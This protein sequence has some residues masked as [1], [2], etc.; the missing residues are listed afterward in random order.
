[1]DIEQEI[2]KL[3]ELYPS[4]PISWFMQI[5]RRVGL[6]NAGRLRGE[7]A[8]A[9]RQT[10][11]WLERHQ[12]KEARQAAAA[13]QQ[14]KRLEVHRALRLDMPLT[15]PHVYVQLILVYGFARVGSQRIF[16]GGHTL[17]ADSV[18]KNIERKLEQLGTPSIERAVLKG[19]LDFLTGQGVVL[20]DPGKQGALSLNLN[21]NAAGV[22]ETGR[23]IIVE[24]KRFFHVRH[25]SSR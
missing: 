3:R 4:V 17:K 19:T 22:T 11:H 14:L 10:L 20:E 13:M 5:L 2:R 25:R 16:A 15:V 21:E 9:E 8:E 12:K 24:V 1:M 23:Q 7:L 18:L 6:E